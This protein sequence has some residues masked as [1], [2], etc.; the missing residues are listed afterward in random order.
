MC[1]ILK[2]MY[3]IHKHIKQGFNQ[4]WHR[5]WYQIQTNTRV[6]FLHANLSA[7]FDIQCTF[8]FHFIF[9]FR[10]SYSLVSAQTQCVLPCLVRPSNIDIPN[11]C[12]GKL[13]DSCIYW[14]ASAASTT[15]VKHDV[16]F[17]ADFYVV[18]FFFFL[19]SDDCFLLFVFGWRLNAWRMRQN[20]WRILNETPLNDS[21]STIQHSRSSTS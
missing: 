8:V 19:V 7:L 18:I 17:A 14:Q 15:F 11:C 3:E 5:V 1:K 13:L 16:E 2:K 21:L 9:S 20:S 6:C 10:I 4:K 12:C